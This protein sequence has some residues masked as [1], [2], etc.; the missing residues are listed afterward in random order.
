MADNKNDD[1]NE[2]PEHEE[3]FGEE[4]DFESEHHDDV[5]APGEGEGAG[6]HPGEE[7][8]EAPLPPKHKNVILPL[9]IG[10][11]VLGFIGWKVYSSL[12]APKEVKPGPKAG[13]I[14]TA[15]VEPK[16]APVAQG[17][18]TEKAQPKNAIPNL[19]E[20]EQQAKQ[21]EADVKITAILQKR[22]DEQF[23]AYKQQIDAI[24][25]ETSTAS[26]NSAKTLAS[27]QHDLAAL[28]ATVQDL[29]AQMKAI[30]DEQLAEKAREAERAAK[31]KQKAKPKE[32]KVSPTSEAF[33]SPNLTV[34]A[35]IPGRAWLRNPEGKTITVTE[36]DSVGEYGKVLKIDAPNGL[37]I[38]SSGV[39]LR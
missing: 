8:Q 2:H 13:Q 37:V 30:K 28:T 34:H 1:S 5:L 18:T 10:V 7:V 12:T 39:T 20:A 16:A 11:I 15:K 35:I 4:F 26:Q 6:E 36:G 19:Y 22:L 38:T 25:K 23:A 21:A 3:E 27:L 29:S 31:A 32:P 33:T 14:E 24:Q 17:A 9:V